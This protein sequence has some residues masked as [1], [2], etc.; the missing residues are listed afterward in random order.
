LAGAV[1]DVELTMQSGARALARGGPLF[2][3]W[4]RGRDGSGAVVVTVELGLGVAA[5]DERRRR[6][7]TRVE[8][9]AP[10]GRIALRGFD[11]SSLRTSRTPYPSGRMARRQMTPLGLNAIARPEPGFSDAVEDVRRLD[12]GGNELLDELRR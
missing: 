7:F 5:I 8:V 12:P 9:Q 11:P 3:I 10:H 6:A 4:I 1:G 2:E